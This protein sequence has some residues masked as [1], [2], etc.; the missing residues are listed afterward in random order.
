MA[1][2]VREAWNSVLPCTTKEQ[3]DQGQNSGS[4]CRLQTHSKVC[5]FSLLKTQNSEY[6]IL[7]TCLQ[8]PDDTAVTKLP[9]NCN[10]THYI[11]NT[12]Q[13]QFEN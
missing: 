13:S 9:M 8:V 7:N 10:E 6:S 11:L 4:L 5:S 3:A 2:F 1:N 12:L